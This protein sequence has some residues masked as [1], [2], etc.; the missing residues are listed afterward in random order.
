MK[1]RLMTFDTYGVSDVERHKR[2]AVVPPQ[3]QSKFECPQ[4]CGVR[5]QIA[6]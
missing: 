1:H 2:E 6:L 3:P 4:L 5:A